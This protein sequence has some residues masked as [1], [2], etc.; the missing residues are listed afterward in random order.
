MAVGL[1]R[2]GDAGADCDQGQHRSGDQSAD[3]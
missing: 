2:V 1:V 3:P